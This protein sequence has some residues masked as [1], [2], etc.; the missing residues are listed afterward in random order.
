M[1][2]ETFHA[3]S[4]YLPCIR[5]LIIS[6]LKFVNYHFNVAKLQ[7][8]LDWVFLEFASN[9]IKKIIYPLR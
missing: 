9:V 7:N 6:T 3:S 5:Y 2:V 1:R 8:N 4:I